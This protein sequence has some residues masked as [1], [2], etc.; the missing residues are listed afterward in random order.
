MLMKTY[1]VMFIIIPNAAEEEIDKV[2]GQMEAGVKSMQGEVVSVEKMGKRKLAY[3]IGK[4]EEGFYVL[5]NI[6][7]NGEV[8][9]EFERRLRVADSVL[10]YITVRVDK[11]LKRVEKVKAIRLKKVRRK[12]RGVQPEATATGI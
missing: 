12:S 6:K 1:E 5:F 2:I 10:R 7:A 3:R 9:K 11:A 8:V 4:F